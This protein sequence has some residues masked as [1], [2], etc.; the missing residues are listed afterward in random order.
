[1]KLAFP[2]M[3]T[4]PIA[5]EGLLSAVGAEVVLPPRPN[6]ET[7]ELG[8]RLAPE[9][10]CVPFKLTLGSMVRCLEAGAD[11]LAYVTGSWSCRF[12]YYGRLQ[13]QILRDEGYEFRLLELRHDRIPEIVGEVLRLNRGRLSA[14]VLNGLRGFRIGWLKSTAVDEIESRFRGALPNSKD[15]GQ[16]R[17][18]LDQMLDEVMAARGPAAIRRIRAAARPRFAALPANGRVRTLRVKLVGESYC[19]V[20][21]F[22]NFGII[23]RMGEMGVLVDPFLTAHRWL[24]FHGFRI[25]NDEV[26]RMRRLSAPYWRYCVGGEDQNSVG[27]LL[28]A[29]QQGFDGVIHVHPFGCMPGTVVQP[30]MAR[31]ARD[32]GIAYLP[33]SLDEHTSE[34]GVLTRLEAFVSLLEKRRRPAV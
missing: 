31:A 19:V 18:L 30:T 24:G 16:C 8:A 5:L 10:M 22:I 29:A 14:A 27:Q 33:L 28:L 23:A 26:R 4:A 13:A 32:T 9:M 17:L 21:P 34:T 1:M 20:E 7:I 15:P 25:G 12:G 11:V 3:G 6:R 2:Y